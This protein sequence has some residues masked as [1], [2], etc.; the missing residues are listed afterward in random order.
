MVP[1][2][3]AA[4]S[5]LATLEQAA[6]LPATARAT[7][8][9]KQPSS[10][11]ARTRWDQQF[12]G[13]DLTD[14]S[15]AA[16]AFASLVAADSG[17]VSAWYNHALCVAWLG[18]NREAI[19]SLDQVVHGLAASQQEDAV[20]TWRLAEILRQGAG[21]E[22]LSDDLRFAWTL[23]W[24]QEKTERLLALGG[25]LQELPAPPAPEPSHAIVSDATL[26]EW[27]DRPVPSPDAPLGLNDLPRVMASVIVTPRSLRLSSPTPESLEWIHDQLELALAEVLSAIR[28]EAT[29]LP[30]PLLDAAVWT[31]R[32]PA[33]LEPGEQA[34][35]SREVVEHYYEDQ[36]IHRP[37][38]GLAGLSPL[39]ASRRVRAGDHVLR[40][41]LSAVIKVREELA[42]RPR[43]SFLYQGYPFDRLRRRLGL[44]TEDP[45]TTAVD[46]PS[47]MSEVDLAGLDPKTLTPE[48]L[49]EAFRSAFALRDD[50]LAARFATRLG[51]SPQ[52]V[53]PGLSSPDLYATLIRESMRVGDPEQALQWI[54]NAARHAREIDEKRT[55]GIWEAEI[56]VR[57]G[58]PVE[59]VRAY[60]TTATDTGMSPSQYLDAAEDLLSHGYPEHAAPFL[61]LMQE[62]PEIEIDRGILARK[63]DLV[64]RLGM[65]YLDASNHDEL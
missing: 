31:I 24:N 52:T 10:P 12:R 45:A 42:E 41:K 1:D 13:R 37:R 30:L 64:E 7:F 35:L 51:A 4:V 5:A 62:G 21:A 26:F 33:G 49:A 2:F 6:E 17:D 63:R 32:Q 29:P 40:A 58:N 28:R 59:A 25:C 54:E 34:R 27:L 3:P 50:R 57:T 36:W 48:A 61:D 47:C 56:H 9:F 14:L 11:D 15:D 8:R 39:E 43:T 44:A 20:S 16:E 65:N 18:R 38:Q 46:D 19:A 60:K 55:Y 22:S 23:D 53:P